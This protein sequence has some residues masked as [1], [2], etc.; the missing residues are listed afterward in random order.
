MVMRFRGF[1]YGLCMKHAGHNF[2]VAS[3]VRING[4]QYI[5]VGDDSYIAPGSF[6]LISKGLNISDEV[7]IGPYVVI[8]DGD[9]TRA[10]GSF[11]F[12]E[13]IAKPIMIGRGCWIGSHVTITKGITIGDGAVVGANSVVTGM[14]HM[15]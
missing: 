2:Q 13:R 8:A 9:H 10:N 5:E 11:R 4:L 12:G 15:T 14:C 7:L 3:N 6:L 1:L